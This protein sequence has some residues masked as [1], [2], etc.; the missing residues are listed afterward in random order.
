MASIAAAIE[1]NKRAVKDKDFGPLV[2]TS[3][4][5]CIHCTRCIRFLT[6]VAGVADLGGIGRGE[7]MEI[8][9]YVGKRSSSELSANIIDLCPVG[10][11]TSKPYAFVAR[12]WELR[13]TE[14]VDVL[15]AVGSNIRVDARGAAVLRILPRLNED[16]E[17]GVDL[18]QDALCRRRSERG[19][20][21]TGPMCAA[22]ASSSRRPGTKLSPRSPQRL[23]AR[24]GKRIAAIAGDLADTEAMFAL[25]ELMASLGSANIDCRQDGAALDPSSRAGYLFNTTIAGIEKADACL[26]IGTNPRY[27]AAIVNARLRKRWLQGGFRVG[28]FGP[29]LDLTFPVTTL[30]DGPRRC[31][32][33][34]RPSRG[35]LLKDAKQPMLILGQGALRRPDGA[36]ILALARA[37][38]ESAGMVRDGLERLQRAASRGVARRRRSISA[39]CRGRAGATSPASSPA[40]RRA[41]SRW[42]ICSAPTRSTP[43]GSARP[44]SSIRAITAI[45][46]RAR[47]DV[48][49]PG[50]AY[51]E[52]DAYLRQHRGPRAARR[53]ARCSR[54]ARRARTGR[55]CARCPTRSAS[56]CPIDSLGAAAPP[57]GRRRIRSSPR[58]TRSRRR[59]WGTFGKA[60]TR[61]CRALRL[62]DRAIS[63]APTRSAA[64]R[65]PWRNAPRR[66]RRRGG[67][68]EDRH[69][70]LS[71]GTAYGLPTAI[72][73]GEI[74]AIIVPLLLAVAYLTYAER[75]VLAAVAAAQGARTSSARSACCSRSPTG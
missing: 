13:K 7:N 49:L 27:E 24:P 11:L 69:P 37:L 19:A 26:L 46:A 61:R 48:V 38:A 41:R 72:I 62:S 25:K 33:S 4:T 74:L 9:T 16:G 47:A 64:P 29:A 30:G 36:A 51:T 5:R 35:E 63:T 42:S 3:M 15:D 66:T 75:K 39:S 58:S 50:A 60:G 52:K 18:R 56:R 70:W 65:R 8:D 10:A 31:R 1:E 28:A 6:D 71:S 59:A 43:R 54:P 34:R 14:S 57:S 12:P 40:R 45:A 55:S 2:E 44:S 67:R 20:G 21:S 68:A 17:R 73:V 32:R 23:K 53:A 22:T